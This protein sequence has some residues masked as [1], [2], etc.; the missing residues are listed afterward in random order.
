MSPKILQVNLTYNIARADLEAAWLEVAQPIADWPGL[1]WKIWS[2][3]EAGNE[4]SGIYLFESDAA[5]QSYLASP[6]VEALSSSP[7]LS[8][9]SVK[10]LDV[11]ESHSA[12]T[13]GPVRAGLAVPSGEG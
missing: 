12:I 1:Q 2:I 13:R 4:F 11:M 8:N 3:N 10:M 5:L 7:V 6:I 9:I